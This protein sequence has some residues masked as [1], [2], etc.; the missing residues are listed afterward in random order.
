MAIRLKKVINMKKDLLWK[1]GF[2]YGY[3]FI[4]YLFSA[5]ALSEIVVIGNDYIATATDAMFAGER[6]EIAAF[7]RP[8]IIMVVMGTVVAIYKQPLL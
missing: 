7:I 4:I 6:V 1:A 8:L 2:Q 3:L 5:F